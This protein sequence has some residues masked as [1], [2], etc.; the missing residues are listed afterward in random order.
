[1]NEN[2]AKLLKML[3]ETAQNHSHRIDALEKEELNEDGDDENMI[4]ELTFLLDKLQNP[5]SAEP[6]PSDQM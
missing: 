6:F 2:L 4:E 3:V 5:E 1:M